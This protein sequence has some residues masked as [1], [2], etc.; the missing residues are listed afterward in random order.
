MPTDLKTTIEA[1]DHVHHEPSGEDWV[2]GRVSEDRVY[3]LGWPSSSA[4]LADCK[5]IKKSVQDAE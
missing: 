4:L 3:P 2:I 1:G 5:L